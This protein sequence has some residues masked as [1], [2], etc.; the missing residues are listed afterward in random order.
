M[1]LRMHTQAPAKVQQKVNALAQLANA[2][3]QRILNPPGSS[4]AMT[5]RRVDAVAGQ[6]L[7]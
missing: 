2:V 3:A 1:P 7:R 5:A 4:S 6:I